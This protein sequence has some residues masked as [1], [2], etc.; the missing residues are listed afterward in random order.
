MSNAFAFLGTHG[1]SSDRLP[2]GPAEA[3]GLP[4]WPEWQGAI[5]GELSSIAEKGTYT[6]VDLPP[7]ANVI[8]TRWVLS[9]KF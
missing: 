6:L 4:D 5:E 9:K 8:G 3:R 1:D 7:D 2:A